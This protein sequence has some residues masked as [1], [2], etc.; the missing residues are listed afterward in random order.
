MTFAQRSRRL[1]LGATTAL[2]FALA[3]VPAIA[4][5][6]PVSIVDKSFDPK[7]VTVSAGD[8][9]TWTVTKSIGEAHS[10]TSGKVGDA[11]AGSKF[12]SG[13]TLTDNGQ[14]FQQTFD[15]PGTYDYFCTVHPAE[16]TGVIMVEAAGESA[17]PSGAAP[18]AAPS[19]SGAPGSAP[20]ARSAGASESP[21]ASPEPETH[22]PVPAE[23]R[24]IGGVI[25]IAALVILFGANLVW[26][27]VNKA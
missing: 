2:A 7:D 23:N 13:I 20:P 10:V 8:T 27:R 21:G 4:A 12:D 5:D 18:S 19:P 25:L 17:A 9:V 24:L 16:M 3:A 26:R 6:H 15:T 14:T 1:A 22:E 11:D